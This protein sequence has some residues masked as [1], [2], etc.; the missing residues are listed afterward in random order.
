MVFGQLFPSV[1]S[2]FGSL[3][4]KAPA[5]FGELYKRAEAIPEVKAKLEQYK[6]P[7]AIE[8]G[9][10]AFKVGKDIYGGLRSLYDI[11][12]EALGLFKNPKVA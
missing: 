4:Q 7:E 8:K 11:G 9:K 3:F 1:V 6:V 12:K 10:E 2:R 5:K